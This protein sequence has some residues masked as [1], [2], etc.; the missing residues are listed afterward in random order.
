MELLRTD[1]LPSK[2]PFFG[3]HGY[4]ENWYMLLKSR[5]GL[6]YEIYNVKVVLDTYVVIHNDVMVLIE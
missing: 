6:W 3:H 2:H 4:S 5:S 1:T